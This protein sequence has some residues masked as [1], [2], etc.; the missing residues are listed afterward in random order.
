MSTYAKF[1]WL[2]TLTVLL[3]TG[4]ATEDPILQL[5]TGGPTARTKDM[6]LNN[7]ESLLI[8]A[9]DD[10][11]IRI[12][13]TQTLQQIRQIRGQVSENIQGAITAIA[14]SPDEKWLAASVFYIHEDEGV[15]KRA[16]LRIHDFKTG[17]LVRLL[18]G[19]T[20]VMHT[21][22][23][24]PDGNMLLAGESLEDKPKA[25]I[26]DTSTWELK[27]EFK[28]HT[29][30]VNSASFTPDAKRV[31]TASFDKSIRIWDVESGKNI[32]SIKNAHGY[33]IHS[34]IVPQDSAE[35]LILTGSSDKTVKIWNYETGKRIRTIKFKRPIREIDVNLE[36]N[37]LLAGSI[38]EHDHSWIVVADINSGKIL[39]E[40]QDHDRIVRA[41]V[42]SPKDNSVYSSGGFRH[43][44]NKWSISNAETIQ[45][46]QGTGN[47]VEAIGISEDNN[48]VYWG[49]EPID[50]DGKRPDS[51]KLA[52]LSNQIELKTIHNQLGTPQ[53][54][55]KDGSNPIRAIHKL[56]KQVL[57]LSKP[58]VLQIK[59][60]SKTT[61]EIKRGLKTG[62][63]HTAYT[64]TPDGKFLVSGANLGYL[65]L[66]KLDG[67]KLADFK[68]HHETI[69]DLAI[70]K[71]G[72]L[73]VSS[74]RDQTFNV[75]NLKTQELIVS[76]FVSDNGEWVAW[77]P[78]G[79]YTSSPDGDRYIGWVINQGIDK[80]ADYV[81]AKQ[82][83]KKL[84]RPDIINKVLGNH[85]LNTTLETSSD[86]D[87]TVAKV[88]KKEVVPLNFSITSPQNGFETEEEVV[89][90]KLQVSEDTDVQIDWSVSVNN[91]QVLNRVATRGLAKA[92]TGGKTLIFPI[93]LD[94]GEN[95][96]KVFANNNETE[97]ELVLRVIR[98][99]PQSAEKDSPIPR[100]L[101]MVAV[102]VNTYVHMPENNL[103]YASK[104]ADT[105]ADLFIQQEGKNYD[106]VESI[107]L[108]DNSGN[109]P[110]RANIV[111]AL[112][113]LANLGPNDTVILFLAGHG[114]IED[115]DYYFLPRD[116][117]LLDS[118][119]WKKSTVIAWNDIQR[120]VESSL[121]RRILLVDTCYSE[122]AFNGRLVKESEDSN[123]IV[124]SSTDASTLAQENSEL[125]HGVFTYAL[126]SGIKGEADS[127]KDGKVTMSELNAF[128]SNAVP[129]ISSNEQR[130]TLSVP[131]GFQDFILAEV[132]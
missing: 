95:L 85:D 37:L 129:S 130:P 71:D 105:I 75:W 128:V 17:K 101:L 53:S 114:I 39:S 57:K 55:K 82:M 90:L 14:L 27:Q 26:W 93:N 76:F 3:S 19:H 61:G 87:F 47:S 42:V 2:L 32:R 79:H 78:T 45:R 77:T 118:G 48:V 68:G 127:F 81:R 92:Q 72:S 15:E 126:V 96:I 111:D 23:F 88:Q 120:S 30:G 35:P 8:T 52:P 108:S 103:Q 98:N 113:A 54:I 9:G 64:F 107:V 5:D 106:T 119:R 6:L 69:T 123:I 104:D 60:G 24:S 62:Y 11:V 38:G 70:S 91:R 115:T 33:R 13:D 112:D 66:H 80:N 83:K 50:W 100:K 59:S 86:S 132:L 116:A 97:K 49:N 56:G 34:M 10:K 102:G 67:E 18:R 117:Q 44:I 63:F 20:K 74:S 22:S 43:Q 12:W 99:L 41:M 36:S 89:N 65:S 1:F 46:I 7:D 131:G 58:S 31:V 110:T 94:P 122:G 73:L 21:L 25:L 124:M 121:G 16:Y 40:Y 125:Q 51:H 4:H 28:G 29:A 109:P 84:Y